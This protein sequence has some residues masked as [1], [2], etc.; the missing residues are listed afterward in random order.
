MPFRFTNT[1]AD[2]QHSIN[3]ILRD[4]LYVFSTAYLDDILI[5][6]DTVK[7]NKKQI[8]I[9]L[10]APS[11]AGVFLRAEKCKFHFQEI[12]YLDLIISKNGIKM[13][14]TKVDT[15]RNLELPGKIK[16]VQMFLEFANFYRLFILRYSR[17]IAPLT[18]LTK[19]TLP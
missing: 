10:K 17:N 1:P 7:D 13:D 6:C 5:Y 3:D 12:N 16:D 8:Q 14:P 4:Y 19:N 11:K 15:V 18:E 2:F 9:I